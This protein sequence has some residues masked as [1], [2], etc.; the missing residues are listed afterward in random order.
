VFVADPGGREIVLLTQGPGEY[1]GEMMLDEGPRSASIM[2][3]D[4]SVS[5]SFARQI[6]ASFWSATRDSQC[7]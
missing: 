6:C 5:S 7:A 2:T 4:K 1:F 3:L